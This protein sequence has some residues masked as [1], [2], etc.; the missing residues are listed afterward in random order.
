L[1]VAVGDVTVNDGP[2]PDRSN[3]SDELLTY[4][5]DAGNSIPGAA[6]LAF[7]HLATLWISRP[8]FGPGELSTIH[9]NLYREVPQGGRRLAGASHIGRRPGQRGYRLHRQ[10][11][12]GRRLHRQRERIH[13]ITL[14]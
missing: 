10:F 14:D 13:V 11:H 9:T 3:L 5:L 4:F 12:A 1:R 8:I 6:A 7:D 2:A